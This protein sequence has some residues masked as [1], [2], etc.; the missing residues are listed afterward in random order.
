MALVVPMAAL[1]DDTDTT[2]GTGRMVPASIDVV[3]PGD[4]G[5]GDFHLG[6]NLKTAVKGSV[7]VDAGSTNAS[8]YTGTAM[9]A[10]QAVNSGRMLMWDLTP[11][12][13]QLRIGES[14]A[15][16]PASTGFSYNSGSLTGDL[17]FFAKQNI[18]GSETPGDYKITIKFTFT[19]SF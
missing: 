15:T 13:T 8:G 17:T 3:A 14:V 5:F 4:F 2:K 9:D 18:D 7:T 11:L 10:N 12:T 1:A 6:D 16:A 19:I